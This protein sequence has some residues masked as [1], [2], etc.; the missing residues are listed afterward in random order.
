MNNEIHF[1]SQKRSSLSIIPEFSFSDT[2][3]STNSQTTFPEIN[4]HNQIQQH[5]QNLQTHLSRL[6]E[7]ILT[8]KE[9]FHICQTDINALQTLLQAIDDIN[10]DSK[11]FDKQDQ[12][13]IHLLTLKQDLSQKSNKTDLIQFKIYIDNQIKKLIELNKQNAK[14]LERIQLIKTATC[15]ARHIQTILSINPSSSPKKQNRM[16]SYQS[17][18]PYITLELDHI[19]QY[20]RQALLKSPYGTIP[21]YRRQAWVNR[22]DD[23]IVLHSGGSRGAITPGLKK[24][25]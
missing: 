14:E 9:R 16:Y 17:S 13:Q 18:Q 15:E 21:L 24:N 20:Q 7:L 3:L 19:R 12:N 23:A 4:S 10:F 11:T 25:F 5:I 22:T 1:T 8:S 2:F 6:K